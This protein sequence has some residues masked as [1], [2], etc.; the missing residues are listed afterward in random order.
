MKDFE[1]C[2]GSIIGSN[3][4]EFCKNNQDSYI[5]CDNVEKNIFIGIVSD[6]CG[7]GKY[8][9]TGAQLGSR[10]LM[11]L[12]QDYYF[13]DKDI[14]L[15]KIS[16]EF[17]FNNIILQRLRDKLNIIIF[18]LCNKTELLYNY[19]LF[20]IIGFIIKDDKLIVFNIGDGINNIEFNN[21]EKINKIFMPNYENKPDYIS[22]KLIKDF[23][24]GKNIKFNICEY[25][26]NDIKS[27]IIG[28]DGCKELLEKYPEIQNENDKFYTNEDLFRRFL[29][30][31]QKKDVIIEYDEKGNIINEKIKFPIMI[32]DTTLI[33]LR[34]KNE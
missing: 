25:P 31:L 7:S 22:Y 15:S 6:G 17:I 28:T 29:F 24:E 10:I 1:Y 20:T 13:G 11:S 34:R 9:E 26:V 12:L 2:C 3:H 4:Y 8:S 32:D 18:N 23:K 30:N 21:G 27:N 19:L 33:M 5:F 16:N 14:Y